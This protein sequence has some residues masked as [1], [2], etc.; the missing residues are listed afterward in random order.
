MHSARYR[1]RQSLT[2]RASSSGTDLEVAVIHW[3]T[4]IRFVWQRPGVGR[5][6]YGG[7]LWHHRPTD[8]GQNNTPLRITE[9]DEPI[10]VLRAQRMVDAAGDIYLVIGD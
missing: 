9:R 8:V 1:Q 4:S 2:R 3:L 10:R 7:E 5:I 6:I